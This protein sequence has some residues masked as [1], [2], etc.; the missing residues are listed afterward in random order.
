MSFPSS[1]SPFFFHRLH[2]PFSFVSASRVPEFSFHG[3]QEGGRFVDR[4]QRGQVRELPV[5]RRLQ[6]PPGRRRLHRR[7]HLISSSHFDDGGGHG[8]PR[9]LDFRMARRR[10]QGKEAGA[11]WRPEDGR[12]PWQTGRDVAHSGLASLSPMHTSCMVLRRLFSVQPH[13]HARNHSPLL[14]LCN[15]MRN[16]P[17]NH[18]RNQPCN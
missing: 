16:R 17:C 14:P 7:G 10:W 13:T 3:T 15:Y 1:R 2:R 8:Q 18:T 9:P 4:R 5:S 11:S 6:G 12:V